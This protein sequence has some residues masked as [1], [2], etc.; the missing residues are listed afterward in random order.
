MSIEQQARAEVTDEIETT[1]L[2]KRWCPRCGDYQ[3]LSGF[4]CRK[5]G[6]RLIREPST[7]EMLAELAVKYSLE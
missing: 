5:C 6:K 2:N 4:D 1:L 7:S 3:E